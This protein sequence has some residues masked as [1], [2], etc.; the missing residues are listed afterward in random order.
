MPLWGYL[1]TGL[2]ALLQVISMINHEP[3]FDEAQAW[4]LARDATIP[5]ML[6]RVLRYEGTPILWYLIL[7]VPAKLGFPYATL[8]IIS[9]ILAIFGIFLVVMYSS[10]PALIRIFYPFTYFLFYQYSIIA[11]NYVL[12]PVVLAFIAIIYKNRVQK[13]KTYGLLLVLMMFISVH[14][15]LAAAGLVSVDIIETVKKWKHIDREYRMKIFSLILTVGLFSIVNALVLATPK[16]SSSL[17][18]INVDPVNFLRTSARV[19]YEIIV[20]TKFISII[21]FLAMLSW[22]WKTGKLLLFFAMTVPIFALFAL[23]WVYPHHT[24]VI[25]LIL[26]FC[27]WLSFDTYNKG[28]WRKP[29]VFVHILAIL[30]MF[31]VHCYWSMSAFRYD[32]SNTYSASKD[33]SLYLKQNHMDSKKIAAVG[34]RTVAILPYFNKNIF[35]NYNN[36]EKPCHWIWSKNY[37]PN[38]WSYDDTTDEAV[39]GKVILAASSNPDV[40]VATVLDDNDPTSIYVPGYKLDRLFLGRSIWRDRLAEQESFALFVRAKDTDQKA[41]VRM[42]SND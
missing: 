9:V 17:H 30:V 36:G 38:V 6:V 31:S 2:F 11:R 7:M 14:G 26:I 39:H 27:L 13:I 42:G 23:S 41:D 1:V 10:F 34:N 4:L 8:N 20:G 25:Y 35:A 40:I 3:W 28:D 15:F 18:G 37:N 16:D 19:I 24:G 29:V 5:D 33:I 22:L 32:L 21:L 12:L